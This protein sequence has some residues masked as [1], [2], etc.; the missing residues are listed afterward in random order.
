VLAIQIKDVY[1]RDDLY[2]LYSFPV[3][4]ASGT[5]IHY[6]IE[7]EYLVIQALHHTYVLFSDE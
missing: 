5:F 6:N 7:M 3:E 1:R 4:V 2:K